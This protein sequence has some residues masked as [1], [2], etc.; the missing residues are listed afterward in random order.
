MNQP[1][2]T[3]DPHVFD[4]GTV[5][6]AKWIILTP[7]ESATTEHRWATETPYLATLISRCFSLSDKSLVL[8]YG[9]GI[10][11]LAKELLAR[12]R[13]RVM[14]VDISPNMR[15]MAVAYVGSD[16][17]SVCSP[18]E[19]DVL[20][21]R[22]VAFDLALA[23]WVLQHCASVHE[24]I[25][26]IARALT[27][28][29]DFFVVNGRTRCVPTVEFGWFDDGIDIYALLKRVFSQ[30]SRGSLPAKHTTKNLSRHASWAAFRRM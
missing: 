26:R 22:G 18:A 14:G 20:L 2:I 11:R 23:V 12:H 7:E 5:D 6:D 16:R 17:F 25:S 10:G 28:H 24:D 19:L 13:C 3:Y 30:R 27:P 9:C 29:G 4:A 1:R 8:D 15:S 21:E